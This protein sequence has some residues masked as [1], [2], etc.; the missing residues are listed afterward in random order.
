M[1]A[2]ERIVCKGM[3][4]L[5]LHHCLFDY[6]CLV[7]IL[8][9]GLGRSSHKIEKSRGVLSIENEPTFFFLI[10]T[11]S[12]R[13]ISTRQNSLY[14]FKKLDKVKIKEMKFKEQ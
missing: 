3:G 2:W 4:E 9:T 10:W 13:F 5:H 6:G 11:S 7:F 12:L 8:D 14:T 1:R